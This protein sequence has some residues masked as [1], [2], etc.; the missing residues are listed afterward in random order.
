MAYV[1]L[2]KSV[3]RQS[4]INTLNVSETRYHLISKD[5]DLDKKNNPKDVL[6]QGKEKILLIR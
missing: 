3:E 1:Q 6:Y 4:L 2:E 5:M